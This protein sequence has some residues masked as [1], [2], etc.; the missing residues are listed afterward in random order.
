MWLGR[1]A[2]LKRIFS[3]VCSAP[4][5]ADATPPRGSV[6]RWHKRGGRLFGRLSGQ[7]WQRESWQ[8]VDASHTLDAAHAD[9][10]ESL[11]GAILPSGGLIRVDRANRDSFPTY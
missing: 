7:Q 3:C 10:A 8:S 6:F 11:A 4:L 5:A 1:S 9:D 2:G